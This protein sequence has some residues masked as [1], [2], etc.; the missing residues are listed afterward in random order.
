MKLTRTQK[1]LGAAGGGLLL[2][3]V[4]LVVAYANL[5]SIVRTALEKEMPGLTFKTLDVGWNKVVVEGVQLQ[6]KGKVVFKV[7]ALRVY[8]SLTSLFSDTIVVSSVEIE[9]PY[10]F[11]V[12]NADG[13]LTLPVPEQKEPPT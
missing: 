8:P 5:T 4:L 3:V 9:K 7:D 13:S 11:I 10:L 12:R 1:I 2:L 6:R